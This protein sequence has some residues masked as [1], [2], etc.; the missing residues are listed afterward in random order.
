MLREAYQGR[1]I[2]DKRQLVLED[3]PSGEFNRLDISHFN[4]INHGDHAIKNCFVCFPARYSQHLKARIKIYV[5]S[6]IEDCRF[7]FFAIP[8]QRSMLSF[9]LKGRNHTGVFFSE[10]HMKFTAR[11][12]GKDTC[13]TVGENTYIGGALLVLEN[14]MITVGADGLWSDDILVQG[15]DSHGVVDIDTLSISNQSAG[16]IT[17]ERHVWLGRKTTI[18]KNTTIGEGAI[19]ATGAVAAKN[20]PKACVAAGVPARIVKQRVSWSRSMTTISAL[21]KQDLSLLREKI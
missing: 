17:I 6:P 7:F 2:P 15:S 1:V 14:T 12:V 20:I 16:H 21:E 9:A 11:M 18:T 4:V 3:M 8:R 5:R 10:H 13:L 19:V